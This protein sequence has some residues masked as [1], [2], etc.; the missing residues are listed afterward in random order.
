MINPEKFL[1]ML[2]PSKAFATLTQGKFFDVK[3][4]SKLVKSYTDQAFKLADLCQ[5][6]TRKAVELCLS[7]SEATLKE[8]QKIANEWVSTAT[9][10]NSELVK[11][12]QDN[13]KEAAKAFELP[14]PAKA[15]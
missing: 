10:A 4:Q 15:A 12:L 9:Q 2:D 11:D 5:A 8:G 6:Q 13:V 14:K 7:Q 1:E 3:E